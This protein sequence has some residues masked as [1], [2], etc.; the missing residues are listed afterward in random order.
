MQQY[1]ILYSNN[2]ACLQPLQISFYACYK[3]IIL[4][5][6]KIK[7]SSLSYPIFPMLF[8]PLKTS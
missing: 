5:I 8:I 1:Q 4:F 3:N 6:K 7:C 2:V